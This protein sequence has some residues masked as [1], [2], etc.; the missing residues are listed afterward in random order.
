MALKNKIIEI[1]ET[2][3]ETHISGQ[4]LADKLSVSRTAVWKAINLLKKEGY[5]IDATTNNG[6]TLKQQS[7]ILSSEGIKLY[8]SKKYKNFPVYVY[9][10]IDSTNTQAK[11]MLTNGAMHGT[12]ITAEEQSAGR[13]RFDR[14]F[15]SP[16]KTGVYMTVVL[17][18]QKNVSDV[19]LITVAAAV[20]VLRA[21]KK[22]TGIEL[23]I[24]WVNDIFL[25]NKKICGI[26]TEAIVD[27]ESCM[28]ESLIVGIG[29]NISTTY[30]NFPNDIKKVATS[31]FPK[32]ISRNNLIAEI[33][34]NLIELC[35]NLTDKNLINEYKEHSIVLGKQ[36]TYLKNNNKLTGKV[37]DIN[38][39]GNLIIKLPNGKTTILESG[40][41][42]I[43]SENL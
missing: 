13:G 38:D 35:D 1:L 15:F 29:I 10:I 31:L 39:K 36:I 41:V 27:F 22:L 3:R 24:K 21:V 9:K 11:K 34:N 12:I 26:L 32:N 40:E 28:A 6:Y 42:S 14:K 7:D 8:L 16:P 17:K 30:D 5:L 37:I 20:S 23:D 25:N 18:P 43:G 2:N 33:V 4:A 19:Q